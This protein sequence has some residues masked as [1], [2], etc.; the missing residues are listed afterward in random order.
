MLQVWR[1]EYLAYQ[2]TITAS[3]LYEYYKSLNIYFPKYIQS[4]NTSMVHRKKNKTKN[5]QNKTKNNDNI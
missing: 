3:G 5:K 2:T 1:A 4:K